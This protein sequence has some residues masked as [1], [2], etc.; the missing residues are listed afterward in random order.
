[1]SQGPWSWRSD[2]QRGSNYLK[3][4]REPEIVPTFESRTVLSLSSG[5]WPN[6]APC[7]DPQL[8]VVRQSMGQ[9]RQLQRAVHEYQSESYSSKPGL[10]W[11][12]FF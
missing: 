4:Y 6:H 5:R 2:G 3:A 11:L 9:T 8:F 7:T 12:R 1:M 10:G